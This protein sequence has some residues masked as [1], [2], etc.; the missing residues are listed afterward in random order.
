MRRASKDG[1]HVCEDCGESYKDLARH[2]ATCVGVC[3]PCSSPRPDGECPL[4][5]PLCDIESVVASSELQE[6]VASDLCDLRH[7]RGLDEVDIKQIKQAVRGWD[8]TANAIRAERLLPFLRDGMTPEELKAILSV[9]V[10]DGLA[11]S[12]M[13]FARAKQNT[14]FIE[15]R[16]VKLGGKD[17]VISFD[18]ASL[19]QRKLVYDADF[20]KTCESRSRVWKRGE[21]WQVSPQA[22]DILDEFDKAVGARFHAELM[23]PA[24]KDEEHD[25][26]VPLLFNC[27]DIE[28]V[29]IPSPCIRVSPPNRTILTLC[30]SIHLAQPEGNISSAAVKWPSS[31]CRRK[32]DLGRRTS[33]CP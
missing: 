24:T 28:V 22:D 9:D 30:R 5:T 3:E 13:E 19:L 4:T 18:M 7:M 14:P 11:T 10:F 20:R 33:C 2:E 6:E 31:R 32:S 29:R 8:A 23:R 27:D 1:R 17:E 12:Y 15:P 26:R 21:H 25:L 16:V